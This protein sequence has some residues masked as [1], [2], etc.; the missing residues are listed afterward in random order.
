M[1]QPAGFMAQ[2]NRTD[3]GIPFFW[4]SISS[5]PTWN[6]QIWLDQFMLAMTVKENVNPEILLEDP[7]EVIDELIPRPETPG[8]NEDAQAV[9]DRE[10]T[11]RIARDKVILENQERRERGPKV[12]HNVF[13]NEVQKRL[14]SRLFLALRTDGKKKFVEKNPHTEESKLEFREMV[15]LVKVSFEKTKRITYERYRLFTRAQETGEALES[16]HAALTAQAATAF[17]KY[18]TTRYPTARN[19]YARRSTQTSY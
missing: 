6:F 14:T 18:N 19:V 17:E 9:A 8:T 7:K 3:M 12:R 5:D 4:T 15:N 11:D 10:A 13:Y 1:A 2:D 16:F